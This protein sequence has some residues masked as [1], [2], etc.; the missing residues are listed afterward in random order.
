MRIRS[1][2]PEFWRSDDITSL[3]LAD[4]LLFVGLWSYVD[5]NGVGLD[6][7]A[8][9]AA[10]LFSGDLE[11]DSRETFARVSGGLL[12]LA[13]ARRITRYTVD[14]RDYLHITNWEKHQ[15]IDKPAKA[16]YPLPTSANAAIRDTLATPSGDTRETL[17]P[18]TGEQGNRG[19]EEQRHEPAAPPAPAD[20]PKR[21]PQ[22]RATRLSPDWEPTVEHKQRATD[23]GVDLDRELVKFRAHAEETGRT[24]K[25]WNGTFTRWLMNAAE[26]ARRDGRVPQAQQP[27][28]GAGVWDRTVHTRPEET[29]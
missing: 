4:R 1:I 15:R 28:R 3:E 18:G 5:D 22:Q 24:S 12:H 7:L 11:L 29:P 9:I 10:D 16:R 8:S 17:A 25:N 27:T 2:K 14:G 20:A 19:T 6:R 23:E 21:T 13:E 26:Y